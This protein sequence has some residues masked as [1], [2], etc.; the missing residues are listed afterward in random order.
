M[1]KGEITRQRIIAEAAP[2]FNQRGYAGCSMQDVM[3]ATGLEKGG[4]YR[5]FESKEELAAEA[6][7]YAI[8]EAFRVRRVG[9]DAI[10]NRVE[11]IKYLV[12]RFVEVPSVLPG[13]C[14][15]MNAA[16]DSDDGNPVLRGIAREA[17]ADWKKRLCGNLRE[18]IERG[19]VREGTDPRRIANLVVAAL[20][21]ALMISR[22][23]KSRTA[24][25]DTA[26]MLEGILDG[27]RAQG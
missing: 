21:G 14:P 13:G 19:E 17:I 18:G 20:E 4:I 9:S 8:A 6:F 22:I 7:K 5:H 23:E 11:R 24:V 3:E 16:I 12:R 1:N 15:I 2:I 25:Q 10:E 27:I 26:V